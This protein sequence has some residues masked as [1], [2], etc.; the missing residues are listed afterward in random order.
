MKVRFQYLVLVVSIVAA[1]SFG[2]IY[3]Y[4]QGM[5]ASRI[6]SAAFGAIATA[7]LKRLDSGDELE[8]QKVHDLL[9]IYVRLGM[10]SYSWYDENGLS[11]ISGL[12]FD[13]NPEPALSS[14]IRIMAEYRRDNPEHDFSDDA[15]KKRMVLVEKFTSE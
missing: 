12:F 8:I 5:E 4:S 11:P 1:F 2:S 14:A 10:D 15:Y 3:G 13:S 9:N 6:E 7:Q